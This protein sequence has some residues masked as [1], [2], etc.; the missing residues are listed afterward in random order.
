MI[1]WLSRTLVFASLVAAGCGG[2]AADPAAARTTEDAAVGEDTDG[3]DTLVADATPEAGGEPCGYKL[4]N[5][6]CDG[7]LQGYMRNEATGL[8]TS[9]TY[10]A[11][12]L[13]DAL[14]AGTQKYG[15]VTTSAYW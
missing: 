15:F 5:T 7:D 13:S 12:K 4:G 3:V 11:F 1:P 8:A 10:G 14:A 9:A 6:L 2:G